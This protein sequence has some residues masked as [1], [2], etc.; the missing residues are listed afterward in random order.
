M[1]CTLPTDIMWLCNGM[2]MVPQYY[3]DLLTQN[4]TVVMWSNWHVMWPSWNV[5]WYTHWVSCDIF[6]DVMWPQAQLKNAEKRLSQ[7]SSQTIQLQKE[8]ERMEVR[9]E[10]DNITSSSDLYTCSIRTLHGYSLVTTLCI[11]NLYTCI[12]TIRYVYLN[13]F[14]L[15]QACSIS[16]ARAT[17][18]SWCWGETKKPVSG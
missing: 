15:G 9:T 4:Q 10:E 14:V 13:S 3:C 18:I 5:M 11:Y 6:F 7:P 2:A 12:T 17:E 16:V 1:S 8:L